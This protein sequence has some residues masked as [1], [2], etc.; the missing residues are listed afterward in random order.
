MI[1]AYQA[2]IARLETE[3]ARLEQLEQ[4]GQAAEVRAQIRPVRLR[5]MDL[6]REETER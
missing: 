5:L 1:P 3:V 4:W 2:Q 6:E